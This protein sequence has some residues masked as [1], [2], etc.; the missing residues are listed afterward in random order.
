MQGSPP[1][2]AG[3]PR[4]RGGRRRPGGRFPD[5]GEGRDAA[6]REA[7]GER[8]TPRGRRGGRPHPRGEGAEA[9]RR[10]EGPPRRPEGPSRVPP[11]A[12]LSVERALPA[13]QRR[14]CGRS[15]PRAPGGRGVG[16]RA[17]WTVRR[18]RV[19]TDRPAPWGRAPP[20]GAGVRS[21]RSVRSWGRA[22]RG[23]REVGHSRGDTRA[24]GDETKEPARGKPPPG[25]TNCGGGPGRHHRCGG[26]AGGPPSP[27]VRG[28]RCVSRRPGGNSGTAR[29]A[30]SSLLKLSAPSGLCWPFRGHLLP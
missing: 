20:P 12:R 29:R 25:R 5:S 10:P 11:E 21:G 16:R 30:L 22:G 2:K 24:S 8:E 28:A 18:R 13:G 17:D 9:H 3:A 14:R 7:G 6:C 27:R 26:R 4:G 15:G 23:A 19:L 1:N